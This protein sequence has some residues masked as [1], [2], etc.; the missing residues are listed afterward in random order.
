MQPSARDI[1]DGLHQIVGEHRVGP[2]HGA[3]VKRSFHECSL[4]RSHA[5]FAGRDQDVN[6]RLTDRHRVREVSQFRVDLCLNGKFV[7]DVYRSANQPYG[8]GFIGGLSEEG[9]LRSRVPQSFLGQ[10]QGLPPDYSEFE[11]SQAHAG[12]CRWAAGGT[13]PVCLGTLAIE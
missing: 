4:N 12:L 8:R 11:R 7:K 3:G 9:R 2:R 6:H 5:F 13:R 10:V 1:I